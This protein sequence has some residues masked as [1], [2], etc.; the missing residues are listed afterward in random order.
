MTDTPP[1][2][3]TPE[4]TSGAT[5]PTPAPEAARPSFMNRIVSAS[6]G[7]PFLLAEERKPGLKQ[8]LEQSGNTMPLVE[9][10]NLIAMGGKPSTGFAATHRWMHCS[11]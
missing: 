4:T 10:G 3:D 7:Q 2:S 8:Y 9:E 11:L 1:P 5:E 6:L